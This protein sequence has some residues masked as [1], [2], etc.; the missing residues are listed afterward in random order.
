VTIPVTGYSTPEFSHIAIPV[1]GYLNT[2]IFTH[3]L[4]TFSGIN[5]EAFRW[6]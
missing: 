4:I 3:G 5:S 6:M 1:T 2:R